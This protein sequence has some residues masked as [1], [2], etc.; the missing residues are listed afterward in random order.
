MS[1]LNRFILNCFDVNRIIRQRKENASILR[2][3]LTQVVDV[4]DFSS[5]ECPFG[6]PVR[7]RERDAFR[8]YLI[9]HRVYCAVHWPFDGTLSEERTQAKANAD[10]LIT[11]PIDH[12]YSEEHME[13]LA[14]LI[15]NY[16]GQLSF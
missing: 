7:I 3:L 2:R 1:D 8:K 5:D 13:Y 4:M 15:Q 10:S 9:Q 6:I 12:R 11:L 16:G 14:D